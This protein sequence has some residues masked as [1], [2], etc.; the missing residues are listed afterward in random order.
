M[1]RAVE[2]DGA[3]DATVTIRRAEDR[4]VPAMAA[5]RAEAWATQ[6]YWIPRVGA[7][8]T[9]RIG[10]REAL[11]EFA[12]FVAEDAGVVV[13]FVAGHRTTRHGCQGELQWMNVARSHQGRG[14]AGKLL[15]AMAAW[16]VE[17]GA[18]R[19]CADVELDNAAARA[20]YAKHGAVDLKPSWMVWEDV[21][22]VGRMV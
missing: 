14:I 7:Y 17:E 1:S 15:A 22:V 11:P 12:M 18:V 6:E 8:L 21:R 20:F 9:G 5:L 13:G 16:F 3:R 10:A 2:E 19:V 4:D